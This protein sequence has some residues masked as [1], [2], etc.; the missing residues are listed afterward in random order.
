[1]FFALN[2]CKDK[3]PNKRK[4]TDLG[5]MNIESTEHYKL[6]LALLSAGKINEAERYF[7][8][9][10][11][12]NLYGFK[13]IVGKREAVEFFSQIPFDKQKFVVQEYI[14]DGSTVAIEGTATMTDENGNVS[15]SFYCD[16]YRFEGQLIKELKSYFVYIEPKKE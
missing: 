7:A 14:I 12:L 1:M 5:P 16:V 10:V 3:V 11:V 13:T 9:D 6:V 8:K 15:E 2:S 4:S